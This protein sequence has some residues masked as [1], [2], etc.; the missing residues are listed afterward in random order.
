MPNHLG[1]TFALAILI[2]ASGMSM[3]SANG[4]NSTESIS[5]VPGGK[6]DIRD[7]MVQMIARDVAAANVD[8]EIQVFQGLHCI[9]RTTSGTL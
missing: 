8:L 2:A 5:S 4:S 1:K 6:G 9:N 3:G 7:E